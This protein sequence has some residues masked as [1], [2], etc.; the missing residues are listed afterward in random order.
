MLLPLVHNYFAQE[1]QTRQTNSQHPQEETPFKG[2][3]SENLLRP[4]AHHGIRLLFAGANA[5][6]VID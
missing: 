2:L 3:Q 5:C 1:S 4:F 6:P